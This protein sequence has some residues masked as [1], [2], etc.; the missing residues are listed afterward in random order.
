MAF[1]VNISATDKATEFKFGMQLGFA[2]VHLKITSRR[3]SGRGLGPGKPHKFG[4]P[5]NISAAAALY[6]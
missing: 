3:K 6:S 4:V 5:C 2:K 1:P